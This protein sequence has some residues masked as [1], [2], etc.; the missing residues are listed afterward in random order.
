MLHARQGLYAARPR[1][2]RAMSEMETVNILPGPHGERL[3]VSLEELESGEPLLEGCAGNDRRAGVIKRARDE[4][5]GRREDPRYARA[6]ELLDMLTPTSN[7]ATWCKLRDELARLEDNA[8]QLVGPECEF[9]RAD[10]LKGIKN[11]AE[12]VP[13][14][15]EECSRFVEDHWSRLAD[16]G[17][18]LE[19][20]M[21]RVNADAKGGERARKY[22]VDMARFGSG[23]E[24]ALVLRVVL[25]MYVEPGMYREAC[26]VCEDIVGFEGEDRDRMAGSTLVESVID[27]ALI[28]MSE[29]YVPDR[30]DA[31]VRR[32]IEVLK[33]RSDG[34]GLN[35]IPGQGT[36]IYRASRLAFN[37]LARRRLRTAEEIDA[38]IGEKYPRSYEFL[39]LG[40]RKIKQM[41]KT[42]ARLAEHAS[43]RIKCDEL[44]KAGLKSACP[45]G[46]LDELERLIPLMVQKGLDKGRGIR[47]WRGA[48]R[49]DALWSAVSEARICLRFVDIPGVEAYP[50]IGNG[51]S[52]DLRVG[53]CYI[54]VLTPEDGTLFVSRQHIDDGWV[55]AHAL[56]KIMEKPQLGSVGGRT[57]VMIVDCSRF[58]FDNPV[59]LGRLPAELARAPQLAGVFLAMF[60]DGRYR[61]NFVKNPA[62]ARPVQDATVAIIAG[63]LGKRL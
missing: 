12:L 38:W 28:R 43:V 47:E 44:V 25:A 7:H 14:L 11:D 13:K 8:T 22:I 49:G 36:E 51:G 31:L 34:L 30:D 9:V 15:R 60:E 40:D 62:A 45:D 59:L 1:P 55:S 20:M 54:E 16:F 37:I 48:V 17:H 21:R 18:Y 23:V 19:G 52:A 27:N 33:K 32:F 35:Q 39:N 2:A 56:E 61:A 46:V 57:T 3:W 26:A 42:S 24:D 29:T 10:T 53:D 41:L 5:A 58:V 63:A 6:F 4:L 50:R